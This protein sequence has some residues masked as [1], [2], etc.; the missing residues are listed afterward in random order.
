MDTFDW[1][2]SCF[3]CGNKASLDTRHPNRETVVQVRTLVLKESMIKVCEERNDNW[4]TE[5]KGRLNC[6]VDL[7]ASDAS[8]QLFSKSRGYD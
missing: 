3:I 1:K 8:Y 2:E 7:V 5:V 4:A 6:C